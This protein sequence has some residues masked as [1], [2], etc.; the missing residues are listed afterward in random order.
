MRFLRAVLALSVALG[1]VPAPSGALPIH[2]VPMDGVP[3]PPPPAVGAQSYILWDDTYQVVLAARN[4][5]QRRAPASTTKIMTALVAFE[6]SGPIRLLEVSQNAADVGESEI[7]LVAG[8]RFALQTLMG[9][10]LVKSANDAAVAVAEGV[11]G[12]V[13]GF[14]TRMNIKASELGLENTHF[15]NPHGLDDPEQY[16][17]AADLLAIALE[18]MAVPE[19]A[20]IASKTD[21]RFPDAPDGTTRAATATNLMLTEYP[22]AIGVKTGF[23][24]D[25]GLVLVAAAERDG[26]RLYAVVMGSE[27]AGGHFKDAAALLD[28]GFDEYGLVSVVAKGNSYGTLRVGR[29]AAQLIA[30]DE[31]SGLLPTNQ[32]ITPEIEFDD[33]D[34]VMIA[35]GTSVPI[36]PTTLDPLPSPTT[37]WRWFL[38]W[39]NR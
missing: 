12:S 34:P 7:G 15:A 36:E 19:L 32:P 22:G 13:D 1:M 3:T 2:I 25:A 26:R 33:G 35:A 8:E 30:G 18:F 24:F 28:Y 16:V 5:D 38:D 10:M 21:Y 9:A 6:A 39:V 4:D 11:G 31:I 37:V 27:G 29:D 20:E 17:S 23:T 14:V